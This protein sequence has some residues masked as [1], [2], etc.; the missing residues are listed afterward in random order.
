M[1][2]SKGLEF[3]VVA[4]SQVLARCP[5]TGRS[6]R[7]ATLLRKP[8]TRATQRLIVSAERCRPVRRSTFWVPASDCGAHLR[9]N[10][11]KPTAATIRQQ[12]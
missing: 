2:V 10:L 1:H 12:A 5:K 3:P 9:P 7:S 4:L 6:R 11:A 8:A